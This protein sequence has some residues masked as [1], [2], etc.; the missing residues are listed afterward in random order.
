MKRRLTGT[1][2]AKS[3]SRRFSH[4]ARSLFS[5]LTY[6]FS[7]CSKNLQP[8]TYNRKQTIYNSQPT[9]GFTLLEMMISVAI[10]AVI[11]SI[12]LINYNGFNSRILLGNLAYDVALSIRQAQVY[13]IGARE[14]ST[15]GTPPFGIYIDEGTDD[16][17][18]TDYYIFFSDLGVT[19]NTTFDGGVATDCTHAECLQRYR[20]QRGNKIK[21]FCASLGVNPPTCSPAAGSSL[22]S[23]AI[24]FKRPDPDARFYARRE[25]SEGGTIVPADKVTIQ[26]ADPT[27]T[28]IKNVTILNTGQI[29]VQ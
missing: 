9:R 11:S 5:F 24:I 25:A 1:E 15:S 2:K 21:S 8:T 14:L 28:I 6:L 17:G 23:L 13:G 19:P 26:I 29:S 3:L 12:V 7:R 27:E 22:Q 4:S 18:K 20:L 16:T 10:F